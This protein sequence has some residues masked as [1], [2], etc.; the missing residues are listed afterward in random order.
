M[1]VGLVPQLLSTAYCRRASATRLAAFLA[2]SRTPDVEGVLVCPGR[3]TT[4]RTLRPLECESR[5][6]PS[7]NGLRTV[8]VFLRLGCLVEEEEYGPAGSPVDKAT[9]GGLSQK[10]CVNMLSWLNIC[11]W[12]DVSWIWMVLSIAA[13]TPSWEG[14]G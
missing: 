10:S 6:R 1:V 11:P 12:V 4:R 7:P 2:S 14:L 5:R 3:T 9:A 8:R 13:R